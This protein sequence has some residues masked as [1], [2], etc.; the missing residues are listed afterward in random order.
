MT[1][2]IIDSALQNTRW[3]YARSPRG[4]GASLFTPCEALNEE[5]RPI[6]LLPAAEFIQIRHNTGPLPHYGAKFWKVCHVF[7][8][9]TVVR[10][11]VTAE[12]NL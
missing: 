2:N 7:S 1:K 9:L 6:R 5:Y 4:A 10:L 8:A 3:H 11:P 12:R